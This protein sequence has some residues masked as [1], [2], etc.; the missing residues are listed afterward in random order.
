MKILPLWESHHIVH[1]CAAGRVSWLAAGLE[2]PR[3]DPLADDHV[4]ELQI[5]V[6]DAGLTETLLRREN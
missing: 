6:V 3:I 2:E 4:G 1:N 5:S